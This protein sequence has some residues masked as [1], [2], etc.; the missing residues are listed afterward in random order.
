MTLYIN[1]LIPFGSHFSMA[2][3]H[4]LNFEWMRYCCLE[5][6]VLYQETSRKTKAVDFCSFKTKHFFLVFD[7][8]SIITQDSFH[9]YIY[10]STF[11]C[12]FCFSFLDFLSD[13]NAT[14]LMYNN[15]YIKYNKPLLLRKE[16]WKLKDLPFTIH[17]VLTIFFLYFNCRQMKKSIGK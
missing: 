1:T 11:N 14:Q 17:N 10:I 4:K 2:A 5:F 16:N 3:Q 13:F 9:Q 15:N 8:S 6:F 7:S 12:F